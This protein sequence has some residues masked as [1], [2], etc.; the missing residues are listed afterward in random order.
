[1]K[2]FAGPTPDALR[3]PTKKKEAYF[4]GDQNM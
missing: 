4:L 2:A 3:L 1:M